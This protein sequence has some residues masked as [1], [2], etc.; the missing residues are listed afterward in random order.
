[1]DRGTVTNTNTSDISTSDLNIYT[2]TNVTVYIGA[3]P[4]SSQILIKV[5]LRSYQIIV[6]TAQILLS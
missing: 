5:N 2:V 6:A 1:M 3:A 4:H